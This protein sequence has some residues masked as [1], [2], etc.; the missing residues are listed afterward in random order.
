MK[1]RKKGDRARGKS[2]NAEKWGKG[3]SSSKAGKKKR[4]VLYSDSDS[5]ENNEDVEEQETGG[6][7]KIKIGR[8]KR[9]RKMVLISDSDSD[10][11]D[12]KFTRLGDE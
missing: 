6:N 8:G 2:G 3:Q 11:R 7:E 4:G 10:D 9:K 12:Y 5:V 1:S